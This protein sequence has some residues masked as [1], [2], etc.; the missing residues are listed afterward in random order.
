MTENEQDR[1]S[2][3]SVGDF[4]STL[5]GPG[6]CSTSLA[7]GSQG[8]WGGSWG[9]LGQDLGCLYFW[10]TI[11]TDPGTAGVVKSLATSMWS[12]AESRVGLLSRPRMCG[13]GGP[14]LVPAMMV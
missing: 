2:R 9:H 10:R 8:L 11:S 3:Y 6:W 4:S 14:R 5:S 12:Q 13:H 1:C 7:P